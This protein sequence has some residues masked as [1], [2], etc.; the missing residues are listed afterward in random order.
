M[1][2][3]EYQEKHRKEMHDPIFRWVC[4][5]QGCCQCFN[6]RGTRNRHS[7]NQRLW[8]NGKTQD[9]EHLLPRE[10][11]RLKMGDSTPLNYMQKLIS[12]DKTFY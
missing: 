7:E 11:K 12:I 9:D 6:A 1:S 10:E 8:H 3:N 4:K 5:V 2:A